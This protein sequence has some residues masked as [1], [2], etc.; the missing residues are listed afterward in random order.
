MNLNNL[1][2]ETG[3]AIMRGYASE[4]TSK[5]VE[6]RLQEA[7][8][9]GNPDEIHFLEEMLKIHK[10]KENAQNEMSRDV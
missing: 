1:I 2:Y 9:K 8:R 6:K 7:R 3:L 10:L 5:Q 4:V